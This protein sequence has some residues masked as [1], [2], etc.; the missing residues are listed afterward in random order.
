MHVGLHNNTIC[1]LGSTLDVRS[2]RATM[3]SYTSMRA[4]NRRNTIIML[5]FMI[6][7][8]TVSNHFHPYTITQYI[9]V[10]LTDG[11]RN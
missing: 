11:T 8:M 4:G 9:I 2:S 3:C 1:A 7:M 5:M 6:T 10:V